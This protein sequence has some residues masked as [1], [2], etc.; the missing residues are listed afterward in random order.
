M[1]GGVPVAPPLGFHSSNRPCRLHPAPPWDCGPSSPMLQRHL[2][3][4]PATQD[5][6]GQRPRA[7]VQR[8]RWAPHGHHSHLSP[9]VPAEEVGSACLL[10][11]DQP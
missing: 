3:E 7:G 6:E 2:D 4:P 8:F 1:G 9:A 11:G 5:L 10:R